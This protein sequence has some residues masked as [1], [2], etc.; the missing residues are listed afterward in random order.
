[1]SAAEESIAILILFYERP[2]QTI[3]CIQSFAASSAAIYVLDN[4]SSQEASQAVEHAVKAMPNAIFWRNPSNFGISAGRNRLVR[5]SSEDWLFL[6]DCDDRMMTPGWEAILRRE[7][8][9]RPDIEGFLPARFNVHENRPYPD[10]AVT[11]HEGRIRFVLRSGSETDT[12]LIRGNGIYHRSLFARLGDFDERLT[13]FEDSELAIRALMMKKPFR[14]RY[15]DSIV[16]HH[17]HRRATRVEDRTAAKVRYDLKMLQKSFLHV[18]M[19][20][21][22]RWTHIWQ[23]WTLRQLVKILGFPKFVTTFAGRAWRSLRP[24]RTALSNDC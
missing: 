21:G 13:A 10:C 6:V 11:V 16:V 8:K 2:E 18:R 5:Q 20:H 9:A 24:S 7:I 3:E 4:G 23:V 12:N 22:L 1:M 19:K 15:L 14:G 17:E